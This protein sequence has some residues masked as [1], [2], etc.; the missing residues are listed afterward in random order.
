[1]SSGERPI[2]AAKGEQS[3]TEALCQPPPLCMWSGQQ[4]FATDTFGLSKC[5]EFNR[6]IDTERHSPLPP[7]P[8]PPSLPIPRVLLPRTTVKPQ[9]PRVGSIACLCRTLLLCWHGTPPAPQP[10]L[11]FWSI[12]RRRSPC[13]KPPLQ[14]DTGGMGLGGQA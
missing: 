5:S 3:D 11:S 13:A 2:G 8:G 6:R 12:R 14:Q 10:V 9:S 1:M 7:L 4:L